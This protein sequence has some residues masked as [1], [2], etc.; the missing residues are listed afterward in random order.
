MPTK[1]ALRDSVGLFYL[2]AS[3]ESGGNCRVHTSLTVVEMA[4]PRLGWKCHGYSG[5]SSSGALLKVFFDTMFTLS[6]SSL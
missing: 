3:G 6:C 1:M 2:D 4:R 5:I